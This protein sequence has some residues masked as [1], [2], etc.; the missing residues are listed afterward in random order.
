MP[1]TLKM[2]AP[3]DCTGWLMSQLRSRQSTVPRR[4][5]WRFRPVMDAAYLRMALNYLC[6]CW[7]T[8]SVGNMPWKRFRMLSALCFWDT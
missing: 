2:S 7:L 6:W 3:V 4:V 1:A 8:M 5:R